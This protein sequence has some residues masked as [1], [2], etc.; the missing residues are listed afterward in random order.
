MTVNG[1]AGGPP[2]HI[3][4]TGLAGWYYVRVVAGSGFNTL[5]PYKLRVTYP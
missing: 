1:Y 5:T 3:D 2:Y 4:Y